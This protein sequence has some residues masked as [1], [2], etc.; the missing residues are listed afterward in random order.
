MTILRI[1]DYLRNH[2]FVRNASL[3]VLTLALVASAM[4]L[5]YKEDI[6][7]FLPL[8]EADRERMAVYQDIS[9]MNRLFIIF[10]DDDDTER[11]N[12]MAEAFVEE[13]HRTDTAGLCQGMQSLFDLDIFTDALDFMYDNIP[14]LLTAE[15]YRRMDS[16][17]ASP[18]YIDTKLDEALDALMFPSGG[19]AEQAISRDPLGL[20]P[21]PFVGNGQ[22]SPQPSPEG[23]GVNG[24]RSM[25]N[26]QWSMFNGQIVSVPSPFGSSETAGN[27]RLVALLEAALEKTRAEFPDVKAHLTGGPQIAV[28]NARQIMRD[29]ILSI[30]LASVLILGLLL[31]AFRRRRDILLV[32]ITVLWGWLFAIG[33]VQVLRPSISM[34][35]VG[36]SSIIIGIAVNYPLHLVSHLRHQPDIREALRE[37][38][39]PLL[40][41]N[42]TTVGAF[43]ALLPLHSACLRDLGLF[44]SLLLLGTIL[45]TLV[46][47]PHQAQA[48]KTLS[49]SPS[50]GRTSGERKTLSN[51][52]SRGRTSGEESLPLEGEVWRG[53]FFLA[54]LLI[55][56]LAFG[57][58]SLSTEF[59]TDPSHLNYMTDEQKSDMMRAQS[60][61]NGQ[62]SAVNGQRSTVNGQ[63]STTNATLY[64]FSSGTDFDEALAA[65]ESKRAVIDSLKE[66]GII[67]NHKGVGRFL[68]SAKEQAARLSLWKAWVERHKGLAEELTRKASEHGFSEDAFAEFTDILAAK[69]QPKSLFPLPPSLSP[70]LA[71]GVSH[72]VEGR[73]T[74]AETLE[75]NREDIG[76]V[77]AF[78]P[79]AF[80]IGS[81]QSAFLDRLS[82]D[83]NYI[84]WVCS[85]VVFVFLWL[86]FRRIELA[87]ISFVPM[88]LS[89]IWILGI[90]SML[91]IQFNIVNIILATF[92]FGQGDDYTIFMTEGCISEYIHGKPVLASYKRSIVLSALIMFVGIGTLITS[93][94][95]ALHS[96]AEVTI[97][98]MASV[99]MM[100]YLV[101][102]FLFRL[103]LKHF[104]KRFENL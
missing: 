51:S 46:W 92:I 36:I 60:M 7:D 42:V 90:M 94:H 3:V 88:A 69:P 84:G 22:T 18:S 4:R 85:L 104:P 15:D 25:V 87:V 35:V 103:M 91:N 19:L 50:R 45:Y 73:C 70:L 52:P 95:P 44:A 100:A 67:L 31:Y 71:A 16:L 76:K 43:L 55:L 29:S 37:I 14:I 66:A 77:K 2:A 57:Y 89:W 20:W 30:S 34:I 97:I 63:W 82:G 99:V 102:P 72:A 58:F 68:P 81:L 64:L 6:Q 13:V 38:T 1:Y 26:G 10:E 80:D 49:N 11:A 54:P 78:L 40:V 9:G 17:L 33:L 96:L 41:G 39:K 24:Q 101:P 56:T 47:L 27:A 93:R 12:E 86:S 62:R 28:G 65:S 23:E 48:P 61:V 98:G 74:V 83:F 32:G 79:E 75:I 5:S 59:D 21:L 53:S 8:S